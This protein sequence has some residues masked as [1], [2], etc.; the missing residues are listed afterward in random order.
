MASV[1]SVFELRESNWPNLR[2]PLIINIIAVSAGFS[3]PQAQNKH[4]RDHDCNSAIEHLK[5][6]PSHAFPFVGEKSTYE[7]GCDQDGI[8]QRPA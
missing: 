6:A 8:P 3:D 5:W 4:S 2:V 7:G 1:G